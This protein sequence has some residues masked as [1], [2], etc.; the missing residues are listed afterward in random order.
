MFIVECAC[1]GDCIVRSNHK[2]KKRK[3]IKRKL[4]KLKGV[5]YRGPCVGALCSGESRLWLNLQSRQHE[6]FWRITTQLAVTSDDPHEEFMEI[7]EQQNIIRV[8]SALRGKR[9]FPRHISHSAMGL[10]TG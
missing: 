5:K 1:V 3:K 7:C 4:K 8:L 6:F 9:G 10:N 2:T